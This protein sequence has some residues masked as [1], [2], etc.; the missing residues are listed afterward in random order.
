MDTVWV[1]IAAG[2]IVV[3]I[4]VALI[5][6]RNT[7]TRR[8]E[9]KRAQAGEL[10]QEAQRRMGTAGQ[11]EAAAR[12]EMKGARREREAAEDALR[13]ADDVDPDVP[14]VDR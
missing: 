6:W 11:R 14:E 8:L 3:L 9:K 5:L 1:V 2:A 7:G 13:R 12:Q 10:R 4:A